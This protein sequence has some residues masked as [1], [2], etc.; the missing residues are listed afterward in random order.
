[1]TLNDLEYQKKV[2]VEVKATGFGVG[3]PL[4]RRTVQRSMSATIEWEQGHFTKILKL[5]YATLSADELKRAVYR[6]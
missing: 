6:S 1:M 2:Y 3:I 5:H 4:G